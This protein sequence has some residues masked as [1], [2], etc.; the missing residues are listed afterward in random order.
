MAVASLATPVVFE[1]TAG[2]LYWLA[3]GIVA[4]QGVL[5]T[6]PH[7]VDETRRR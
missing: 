7:R 5:A 4:R 6:M 2:Q 1:P 3:S